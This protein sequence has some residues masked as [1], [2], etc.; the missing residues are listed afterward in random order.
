MFQLKIHWAV[1]FV[2]ME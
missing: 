2:C 1:I